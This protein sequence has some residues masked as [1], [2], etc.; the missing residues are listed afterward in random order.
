MISPLT[1]KKISEWYLSPATSLQQKYFYFFLS[2]ILLTLWACYAHSFNPPI[3]PL[4]D[5]YIILHNAKVMH[6]GFDPNYQGS[7]ALDGTTSAIYL[8]LIA[9]LIFWVSPLWAL[10]TAGWLGTICYA[11]LL[12]RLAFIYS[13]SILQ[14][15]LFC[16]IGLLIGFVTFQFFN[17]LETVIAFAALTATL[18]TNIGINTPTKRVCR[19][20]L[21]GLLPFLRPE[22]SVFSLLIFFYQGFCYRQQYDLTETIRRMFMDACLM[23]IA[24]LPWIL[25]YWTTTGLPFPR[26]LLAKKYFFAERHFSFAIKANTFIH[27]LFLFSCSLGCVGLPGMMLLLLL[28]PLGRV[29]LIFIFIFLL[30]YFINGPEDLVDNIFRYTYLLLPILL[31]G[32]ISC[33][34]HP[35][36]IIVWT[37]NGLIIFLSIF[38]ILFFP[39]SWHFYLEESNKMNTAVREVATWCQQ[40]LPKDSTILIHDAGYFAYATSFHLV[41]MVGLKTPSVISYEKKFAYPNQGINRREAIAKII[42]VNHLQYLIDLPSWEKRFKI[43]EGLSQWGIQLALLKRFPKGYQVY[44]I[45]SQESGV[46]NQE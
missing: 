26:T 4:D 7:S 1:S 14:T 31:F 46:R 27:G 43:T 25:W 5:G 6:L 37:A 36:K 15:I 30:T 3:F 2:L 42:E 21:C 9:L 40:H 34:H 12:S 13:A 33:I 24:A 18:I 35:Q 29:C 45:R 44:V 28:T 17:G 32:V 8:A 38:A 41:D 39:M 22:L 10:I 19:N 16:I 20:L 23:F 11:L